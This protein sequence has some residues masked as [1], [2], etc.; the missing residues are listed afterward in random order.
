M[1]AGARYSAAEFSYRW[2]D[3]RR[4]LHDFFAA[5]PSVTGLLIA[6]QGKVFVEE[7]RHL[8]KP[9]MRMQSWSMACLVLPTACL[10]AALAGSTDGWL[11]GCGRCCGGAMRWRP[12]SL[13]VPPPMPSP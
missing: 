10:P 7:Y 9:S 2:G 4:S 8:R 6:R 12:S 3:E 11:C 5:V 1:S 13:P